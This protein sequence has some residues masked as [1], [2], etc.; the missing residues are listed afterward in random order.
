MDYKEFKSL[1]ISEMDKRL[2]YHDSETLQEWLEDLE[3]L[4]ESM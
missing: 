1:I 3:E 4:L 2:E